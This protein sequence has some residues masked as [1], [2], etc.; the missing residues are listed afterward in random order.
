MKNVNPKVNKGHLVKIEAQIKEATN[1]ISDLIQRKCIIKDAADL[2]ALEKMIAEVADRLAALITAMKIQQSLDSDEILNESKGLVKGLGKKMKNQGTR[3]VTVMTLRGGTVAAVTGYY[4]RK[5]F[6]QGIW[7]RRRPG[8][9][10]ALYLSG[11]HDHRSPASGAEISMMSV[12]LSTF[13]E[14]RRV[15]E[16]RGLGTNVKTIRKIT[17]RFARR[18][19]AMQKEDKDLINETLAGCRAAVSA[20]GGRMRIRQK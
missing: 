6:L 2:E 17:L 12:I 3:E 10:P 7:R 14:A 5:G 8:L 20:D 13:E 16:E 19:P 1:D 9:Y 11:I 15:L 18:A 4:S